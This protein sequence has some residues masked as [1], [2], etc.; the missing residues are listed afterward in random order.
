MARNF[1]LSARQLGEFPSH[2]FF[3]IFDFSSELKIG[4]R[5]LTERGEGWKEEASLSRRPEAAQV[6]LGAV[7]T[8]PEPGSTGFYRE[9]YPWAGHYSETP[10][11]FTQF[12]AMLTTTL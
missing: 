2:S 8:H 3:V 11:T 1:F 10:S 12:P 4:N 9:E 6:S 7:S 5:N